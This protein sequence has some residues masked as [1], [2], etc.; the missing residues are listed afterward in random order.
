MA[1]WET[2][3]ERD[4]SGKGVLR[5][6]SANVKN[7]AYV[8]F[9]TVI[10][11]PSNP[12]LNLNYNPPRARYATLCFM[13]QGYLVDSKSIDFEKQ[14][15][16]GVN[17]ISGQTLIAVKCAYQGIL[18]T[19]VNLSVGL[20]QTPGGVGLFYTT[21]EDKIKDYESLRLAWDEVRVVCYAD[22]ALSLRLDVLEYDV[23]DS[24]RDK[25][26]TPPP[27]PPP[28]DK[29]PPGIPIGEISP[30]YDGDDDDGNTVP[31]PYDESP[32]PPADTEGE[33]CAPYRLNFSV[34]NVGG[35]EYQNLTGSILGRFEPSSVRI[36]PGDPRLIEIRGQ[37]T[38]NGI[39]ADD[40]DYY[41][42]ASNGNPVEDVIYV[43][44]EIP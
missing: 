8:L 40:L 39:C 35:S 44:F 3:E 25:D 11:E 22:T 7:R 20:S 5:V 1:E 27:S 32:D 23:C 28:R 14:V 4:I 19:F 12:Y 34:L 10:R 30:P 24:S 18:E 15:W 36:S 41:V 29:V 13:R 43:S 21:V 26:R 37:G 33:P 17:D 31:F 6:P 2:V 42:S 16:D 9:A 38:G